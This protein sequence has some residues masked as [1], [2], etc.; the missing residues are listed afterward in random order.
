ML[1]NLTDDKLL[2]QWNEDTNRRFVFFRFHLDFDVDYEKV[3]I[4]DK[5]KT[6]YVHL[7]NKGEYSLFFA[8]LPKELT[9]T[10]KNL[11]YLNSFKVEKIDLGISKIIKDYQS[12]YCTQNL[13]KLNSEYHK[14]KSYEDDNALYLFSDL[15]NQSY[16]LREAFQR[17]LIISQIYKINH[18]K[19]LLK[20]VLNGLNK[21]F[22]YYNPSTDYP[23][24]WWDYEIGIPKRLIKLFIC[25]YDE[26]PYNDILYYLD[27]IFAFTPDYHYMFYR[28]SKRVRLLATGANFIDLLDIYLWRMIF[29]NQK[30]GIIQ[31]YSDFK[32]LCKYADK[33]DGF[34][35]DG[36]FIQHD[37]IGY[38]GSYGEVFLTGIS[39]LLVIYHACQVDISRELDF[40]YEIIKKS[41]K[42]ILY[43]GHVLDVTRGRSISREKVNDEYCANRILNAIIRISR[44]SSEKNRRELLTIILENKNFN[45]IN[46]DIDNL[47]YLE[48]ISVDVQPLPTVEHTVYQTMNRYVMR[49]K[50]YLMGV[51]LSSSKIHTHEYMNGENKRGWYFSLG[52]IFYY[53]NENSHYTYGYYPT[54]DPYHLPGVTNTLK[55]LDANQIGLPHHN[56]T[57]LGLT[58]N[59]ETLIMFDLNNPFDDL[60]ANITYLLCPDG[61]VA[62][63]SNITSTSEYPTVTN[64]FNLHFNNDNHFI[65][66]PSTVFIQLQNT[67]LGYYYKNEIVV[68]QEQRIGSYQDINEL[69]S[70]QKITRNY[71]KCWINHGIKPVDKDFEFA[72]YPH[73]TKSELEELSKVK[74]YEIIRQDETHIIKF[75]DSIFINHFSEDKLLYEDMT[76][77]G[78]CCMIINKHQNRIKLQL[79]ANGLIEITTRM[80]IESDIKFIKKDDDGKYTYQFDASSP[81]TIYLTKN[82]YE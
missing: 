81:I 52:Y 60:K 70:N 46:L 54:I 65:V 64:L 78:R 69:E 50:N 77:Y 10:S 63:G 25:L 33:S 9:L 2:I 58:N 82:Y 11:Q 72:I 28:W 37:V 41:F 73:I 29:T 57:T 67:T 18:Q 42:P 62:I 79:I 66:K 47:K 55:P 40:I 6:Y 49:Q 30:D 56:K 14:F 12:I 59:Q 38:N 53:D 71:L 19:I 27:M 31:T 76:I 7:K 61:L 43:K 35:A 21:L 5:E 15:G 51:S 16:D 22:L 36:S 44:L 45:E 80:I 26:I 34:Y 20:K 3:I 75:A 24:N 4:Q 17:L 23:Q 68:R 13:E 32:K 39:H 1:T 8:E 48:Q 74:P